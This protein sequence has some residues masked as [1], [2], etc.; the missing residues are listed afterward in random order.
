MRSIGIDLEPAV[1]RGMLRFHAQRPTICG[2]EMHLVTIQRLMNQLRPRVIIIDPVSTFAALG[3]GAEIT[4][5]LTRLIGF[6]K[7][8][9]ITAFFT[10]LSTGDTL[11]GAAAVGVSS[12]MDTWLLLRD[13][14]SGAERNRVLHLLKSRGMAHSNQVR[15]FLLTDHGVELRDVYV[16]PSGALTIG[17]AR[18]E[19][20]AQEKAQAL[21]RKQEA[22][23]AKRGQ[24]RKRQAM[25][26]RRGAGR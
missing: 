18:D 13:L 16:G 3:S 10:S 8:R 5:M 12:L 2:L 6:F 15:E 4:A 11:T 19:L 20:E 21:V 1:R 14:Q 23:G 24:E 22:E 7:M 9:Q 17:S 26:A 25:E